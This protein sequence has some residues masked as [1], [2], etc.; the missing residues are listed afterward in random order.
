[1]IPIDNNTIREILHQ[2]QMW[3]M[4][5]D[6][7]WSRKEEIGR[8]LESNGI[9]CNTEIIL[10]GAG[11][12][13]FIG[14]AASCIFT[15]SGF[16]N[17]RAVAT[18]DIVSACES[19]ISK[20]PK[21]F[22]SFG[23]SGDSPESVAAYNIVRAYCQDAWHLI[24]TCNPKG[25]LAMVADPAKDLV[26]VLPDGTNDRSL[27][28]TSSFSS[29][30]VAS[31]LCKNIRQIDQERAKLEAAARFASSILT[32]DS[33]EVIRSFA[34][35]DIKRAV[36]LG[37]GAL[38]GIACECHLKLQ[39]L[40]DGQVMCA[41]D[42]FM[43]LR[44]GPKAVINEETLVVYLLSDDPYTHRYE[45]DLV[46]QV[47]G[48]NHPAAQIVVSLTPSLIQERMDLEIIAEPCPELLAGEYK[49]V[50]YVIVGQ[51]LGY[52][53]SL[54]RNLC[55]DSPSVRGTITRVVSGVKIYD[56]PK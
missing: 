47:N 43:G 38:K 21:L 4:T 23:R 3:L 31:I 34:G 49:Y 41:F 18:T 55:P 32:E 5:Y 13:D 22:I 52:F 17:V 27:A 19:F 45:L 42:S 24:I 7:I 10:T 33:L 1:M 56:L 36:F 50:P 6:I 44:H 48:Q 54:S 8:F 37:S 53:F 11:T 51:L 25:Y 20:A 40:T 16:T 26:I 15:K 14:Q 2:P 39:E 30:L 9:D 28:M 46:S 35:R 29:M 12:S